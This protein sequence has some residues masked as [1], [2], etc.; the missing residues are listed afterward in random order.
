[1]C[2]IIGAFSTSKNKQIKSVKDARKKLNHRGPDDRGLEVFEIPRKNCN[3]LS[4]SLV[5]GHTRLSILDLSQD[6]QQPMY[7]KDR[8]Y[9]LTFNGEIYNYLEVRSL[10]ESGGHKFYS[11]TDTEVLLAAWQKWGIGCVHKLKGMFSF[12]IFDQLQNCLYGVRDAFGIKPFFY[13]FENCEL[14]FSSEIQGL[15]ELM[16]SKPEPNWGVALNYLTLGEVDKD[17]ETFYSGIKHLRPGHYLKFSLEPGTNLQIQRWWNPP[18]LENREITFVEA[19][20]VLREKFLENV[21][22]HLRSDVPVGA[23][24]S[25]GIDSSAVVCAIRHLEPRMPIRTFSFISPLFSKNEEKWIDVVNRH[26]GAISNKIK[27][28][29]KEFIQDLDEL[30]TLQGEPFGST[31]IYAQ[32]RVFKK[33]KEKGVVVSLDGQGADEL[34]AG[35]NGYPYAR[36]K[37]LLSDLKLR[38]LLKLFLGIKERSGKLPLIDLVKALKPS[39]LDHL[40]SNYRKK[41]FGHVLLNEKFVQ[42]IKNPVNVLEENNAEGK[43]FLSMCL[44]DALTGRNGLVHLL[45][46]EDRNSM[47]HSIES[48][49]PFLTTDFAE[50]LLSLPENF[51][52]S[53]NGSTKC[54]FRDSMKGIVPHEIL[55]RKDKVGFETPEST[56]FS[57]EKKRINSWI[58]DFK[59][60]P[61]LDTYKANLYFNKMCSE[62]NNQ[63][64]KFW[65]IL[66]FYKWYQINY[67]N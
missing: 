50:F 57:S 54:I 48:R 52:L 5:L 61:I 40:I 45:R 3:E 37:S 64:V 42:T 63:S 9:V 10:L 28:E 36:F 11:K 13:S 34:L 24:L 23:A 41:S 17:E 43:R 29:P 15:L 51:L 32:F 44:K 49:V 2:G 60:V 35:Y 25:G 62:K 19:S 53:D 46:Y 12:V 55:Q 1:M 22:L 66:N 47:I 38:R 14:K 56:W 20:E 31:S 7:S 30:I 59:R 67:L 58:D 65:R 39:S 26:V 4:G 18:V 6:G 33:F 8:R 21:R 27:I 16:H